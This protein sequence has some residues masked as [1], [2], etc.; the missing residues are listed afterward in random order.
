MLLKYIVL[1]ISDFID[2]REKVVIPAEKPYI[3]LSGTQA[4]NTFLIWS[5]GEDILESPTLTIFASDFVCRFLTIQ[6]KFGTAGRAVAL[7]V[8]ADKAAFYGCVIT[9]YQDTLLDDNGN[10][11]FKNCYIEGA[12]DFIC[13]S[14]SSLYEVKVSFTL[15]V[16][17]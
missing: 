11:Y 9:S 12:T 6:N 2:N 15:V 3:T 13:G 8:A 5:D 14:A 1:R 10:H 16:A 4:S 7:R 17:E